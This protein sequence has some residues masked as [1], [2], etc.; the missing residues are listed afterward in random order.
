MMGEWPKGY[1]P[2]K[3]DNELRSIIVRHGGSY[4]DVLPDFVTIPN[5][6]WGFFPIDGHP[7]AEGHATITRLLANA[8]TDGAVP[9]LRAG[10][11]PQAKLEQTK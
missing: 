9:A 2:F 5:P 7:N 3:L 6:H 4:V 1:D 8:L 11:Q 10:T